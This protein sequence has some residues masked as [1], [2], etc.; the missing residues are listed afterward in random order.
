MEKEEKQTF[1]DKLGKWIYKHRVALISVLAILL[2]AGIAAAV[3]F[4]TISKNTEKKFAE[5]D[6]MISEYTTLS[7]DFEKSEDEKIADSKVIL[8]KIISF[9]DAN[10]KN[11]VGLRA[12]MAAA[13]IYYK[14]NDFEQAAQA[15]ENAANANKKAYTN[16]LSLYNAAVCYEELGNID[17]VIENLEIVCEDSDFG[18]IAKALFNLARLQESKGDVATAI[19][20]Y[21]T[22]ISRN[23][24]DEWAKLAKSRVMD[25]ELN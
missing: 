17:K 1:S 2:V 10:A 23:P 3:I 13:E 9:A 21:N 11:G 8:D 20:T 16:S 7:Y 18:M 4:S 12:Y 25:L 5:L 19:E 6:T 22:L 14:N 15:W 24:S